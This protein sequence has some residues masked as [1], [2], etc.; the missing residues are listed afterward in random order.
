MAG[1]SRNK[2][3]AGERELARLLA[4]QGDE[5]VAA[6]TAASL[7]SGP[8]LRLWPHRHNTDGFYAAVWQRRG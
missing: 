2:G 8:Y 4:E 6:A 1:L 5:Q 3:K 7:C